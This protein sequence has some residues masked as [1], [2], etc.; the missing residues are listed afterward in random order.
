MR[1]DAMRCDAVR[2]ARCC[3]DVGCDSVGLAGGCSDGLGGGNSVYDLYDSTTNAWSVISGT[4]SNR[5]I[6]I[7]YSR[8]GATKCVFAGGYTDA[9][10]GVI[11]NRV[12]TGQLTSSSSGVTA[13]TTPRVYHASAAFGSKFLVAGGVTTGYVP[14][15]SV[16]IYDSVAHAWTVHATVC[17][18]TCCAAFHFCS[19]SL[20]RSRGRAL[21]DWDRE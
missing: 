13:L 6:N 15:S 21:R 8:V 16:E 2:C 9:F 20:A 14:I 17:V 12:Q 4:T 10:G 3:S 7:A 19:R 18:F 5:R 1:C 11:L